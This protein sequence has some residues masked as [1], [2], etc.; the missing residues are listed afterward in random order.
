MVFLISYTSYLTLWGKK[1]D[2]RHVFDISDLQEAENEF[3]AD[4]MEC[5]DCLMLIIISIC[6]GDIIICGAY[7]IICG[8][9]F[10]I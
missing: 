2:N 3:T 1:I 9:Y 7:F 6:G 4:A 10:I 8:A 5:H